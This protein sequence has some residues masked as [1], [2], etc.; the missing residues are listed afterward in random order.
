[1][2]QSLSSRQLQSFR[3][4]L[5]ELLAEEPGSGAP[6]CEDCRS[7]LARL[8]AGVFGVCTVCGEYIEINRLVASPTEIYCLSCRTAA[9]RKRGC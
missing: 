3:V 1:M 7:A 2:S 5:E 9:E 8:D 4:E 6:G